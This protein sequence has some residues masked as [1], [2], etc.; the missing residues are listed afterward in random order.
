MLSMPHTPT[1]ASEYKSVPWLRVPDHSNSGTKL[2]L[3]HFYYRHLT[4]HINF[5]RMEDQVGFH[6]EYEQDA[7]SECLGGQ[8]WKWSFS[9]HQWFTQYPS[10]GSGQDHSVAHSFR[11]CA[12][13]C[14]REYS[15]LIIGSVAVA[16]SK[17]W[18][19]WNCLLAQKCAILF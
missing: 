11:I 15:P 5:A 16:G 6:M 10:G 2:A 9:F 8:S 14:R 3:I 7:Q 19:Y 17:T 18:L 13:T 12:T 1:H 4:R